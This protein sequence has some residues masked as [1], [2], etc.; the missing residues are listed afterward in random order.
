MIPAEYLTGVSGKEIQ[1][2]KFPSCKI[3]G[4]IADQYLAVARGNYQ[5]SAKGDWHRFPNIF[6]RFQIQL[7]QCVCLC[8]TD[9][10]ISRFFQK[11]VHA[12]MKKINFFLR[13]EGLCKGQNGC[14]FCN[15]EN[16]NQFSM[17]NS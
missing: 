5:G 3:Q 11:C 10:R 16:A 14:A 1:Q 9:I 6:V 17:V 2:V 4:L 7:N 13:C 12:R 15:P 8:C